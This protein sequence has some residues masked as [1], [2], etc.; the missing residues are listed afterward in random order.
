MASFEDN[1]MH[2]YQCQKFQESECD[3]FVTC[4]VRRK[5]LSQLH[6]ASITL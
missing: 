1:F 3:P 4:S 6:V 2:Y 5:C